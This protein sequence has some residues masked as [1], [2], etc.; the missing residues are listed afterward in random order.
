LLEKQG[1]IFWIAERSLPTFW[2]HNEAQSVS[3]VSFV[4]F[5]GI[6]PFRYRDLF[7]KGRRKGGDGKAHDDWYNNQE[8]PMIEVVLP[9]WALASLLGE[10]KAV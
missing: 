4:P 2:S 6:S 8:R 5:M 1:V 10:L 9:S 7:Q 3:K